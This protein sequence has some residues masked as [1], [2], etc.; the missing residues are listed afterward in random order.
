[1][2]LMAY[3][4]SYGFIVLMFAAWLVSLAGIGSLQDQCNKGTA[5]DVFGTDCGNQHR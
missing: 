2:A 5:P 3:A 1:M 4:A